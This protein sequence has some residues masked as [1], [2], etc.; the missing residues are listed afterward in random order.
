MSEPRDDR[1]VANELAIDERE[2]IGG[3][4]DAPAGS[5]DGVRAVCVRRVS[6]EE[7]RANV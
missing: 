7:R 6:G 2:L 3:A 1:A 4:S 5:R